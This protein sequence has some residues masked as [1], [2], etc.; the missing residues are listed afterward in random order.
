LG[1]LKTKFA[2]RAMEVWSKTAKASW[3]KEGVVSWGFEQIPERISIRVAGGSAFAY[4]AVVDEGESVSLR[5]LS[6]KEQ[7]EKASR[8]GV[9]RL[10]LLH[11]GENAGRLERSLPNSLQMATLAGYV[12]SN[13]KEIREQMVERVLD[14]AFGLSDPEEIPRTKKVFLS[15]LEKGKVL[16]HGKIAQI[17]A[18]ATEVGQNL[19]KVDS[20]LRNLVGKPGASRAALDDVRGQLQHLLP[21]G[22]FEDCGLDR[23]VHLPR[24]LRGVQ[25]RLERLPNDPRRDADK[26]IQVIPLCQAYWERRDVLIKRGVSAEDLE[27][28][29]WLIEELRVSLF[30]P[31]LKTVVPVSAQ[32]VAERWKLLNR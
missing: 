15:R 6:S 23:I 27:A 26:A 12:G 11:M 1:Q 5:A 32:K 20:T 24:Y 21:K 8:G 18:L 25:I 9:R 2:M 22:L 13:A 16:L 31:E 10:F 28:Y 14:D 29:R 30:A 3:E 4:P 7:A 17:G 19:A